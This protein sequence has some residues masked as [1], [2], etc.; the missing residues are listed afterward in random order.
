MGTVLS[1]VKDLKENAQD[2]E[3]YPTT[4]EMLSAIKADILKSRVHRRV[5]S[6]EI[7]VDI[8]DIGAGNGS[9]LD[10]LTKG[11]KYAI[12]KSTILISN[13]DKSVFV[14]GTDFNE[15]TLIDKKVDVTFSNPPYSLFESWSTR[16]ILESNSQQIY[17]V[18][19]ERWKDSD[20]IKNA[21]EARSATAQTIF[22]GDFLS[23]DRKAR[24]KIEIVKISLVDDYYYSSTPNVEPFDLW[25]NNNFKMDIAKNS[26]TARSKAIRGVDT[27]DQEV[28]DS[29]E[30]IR[31]CGLVETLEMFYVRDMDKLLDTYRNLTTIDPELLSEMNINLEGVQKALK[32]KLSSMKDK[33]WKKLFSE[34]ST[35]TDRLCSFSRDKLLRKLLANTSIDFT[36][37]NAHAVVIWAIKNANTF[38]DDQ[39]IGMVEKMTE[40][41]NVNLYL[42][43]KRTFGQNEWRYASVKP[44]DLD[45]YKLDYRVIISTL[46]GIDP[47]SYKTHQLSDYTVTFINDLLTLA[48]NLGFDSSITEKADAIKIEASEGSEGQNGR[49]WESGK[50]QFFEFKNHTTGRKEILFEAKAFLNGN[51]HIKFNQLFIMKLNVEFGR[52]K[53]WIKNTA[54]AHKELDIPLT[55][56]ES[57]FRSNIKLL[58]SNVPLLA[59][60]NELSNTNIDYKLLN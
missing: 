34:L 54:E 28:Q 2:Y 56:A 14:V 38:F 20:S 51:I 31:S 9:A 52:L 40:K 13:M 32:L 35:I 44:K 3:W 43:N 50:R 29:K 22:K 4:S 12:E 17:L 5:G 18:I 46:G 24:A 55:V 59:N 23:A 15:S 11:N 30:L 8:L 21:I 16:I 49:V 45:R 33:Y 42:S 57:A 10:S 19:P 37:S 36:S 26:C 1:L 60:F 41:A 48:S 7:T 6:D 47:S 53:G 27:L 25:F 58:S 39:L